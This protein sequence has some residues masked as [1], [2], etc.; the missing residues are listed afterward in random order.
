MS[1]PSQQAIGD[2]PILLKRE[3]EARALAPVFEILIRELGAQRARAILSEAVTA[4][5]IAEGKAFAEREEKGASMRTFIDLQ[6]L[7]TAGGALTHETLQATDDAYDYRVTHCAYADMY[8][9]LGLQDVGT[10]LSCQRDYEF[11]QGYDPTIELE[12]S[13]SIMEGNDHCLFRYRYREGSRPALANEDE[14][15]EAH[16]QTE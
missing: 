2:V 12:R 13:A 4:H 15:G 14:D 11:I 10:I 1:S 9:R 3:I 16:S 7:W 5:S 6:H 8:A